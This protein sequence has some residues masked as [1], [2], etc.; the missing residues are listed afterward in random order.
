MAERPQRRR[1]AD[2]DVDLIAPPAEGGD[3]LCH[4]TV[5][6]TAV[7]CIAAFTA[8]WVPSL[9]GAYVWLCLVWFAVGTAGFVAAIVLAGA[10]ALHDDVGVRSS[11]LFLAG[12]APPH[13]RVRFRAA[14]AV[15]VVVAVVTALASS[16]PSPLVVDIPA[17]AYGI[18]VPILPFAL[19]GVHGA[20]YCPWPVRRGG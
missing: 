18:L 14:M 19:A 13:L 3:F 15:T 10:R 6:M 1:E 16:N 12:F 2:D 7:F 5:A 17:M 4:V 9:R 11:G 20:R 8:L